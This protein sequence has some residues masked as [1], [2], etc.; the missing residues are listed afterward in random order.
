MEREG[1]IRWGERIAKIKNNNK[2]I[3]QYLRQIKAKM[4]ESRLSKPAKTLMIN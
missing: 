3:L 2:L 4:K 1:E